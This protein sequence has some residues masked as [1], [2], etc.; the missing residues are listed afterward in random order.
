MRTFKL[1][2][3]LLDQGLP[4]GGHYSAHTA[5]ECPARVKTRD[6]V[7]WV[8]FLSCGVCVCVCVCVCL[9]Y[10]SWDSLVERQ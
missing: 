10:Y 1:N 9:T 2:S 6:D 4:K 8:V 7:L 5:S 3:S